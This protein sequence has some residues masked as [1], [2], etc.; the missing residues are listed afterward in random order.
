MLAAQPNAGPQ[1][2]DLARGVR[3]YPVGNYLIFYT[4]QPDG[5]TVA[6]V[7]HGARDYRVE[8]N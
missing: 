5:I 8:F 4:V 3:F 1:R 6:R 7:I 2:E